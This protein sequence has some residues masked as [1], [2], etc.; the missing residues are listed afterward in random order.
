[1]KALSKRPRPGE[2]TIKSKTGYLTRG[3][4]HLWVKGSETW[5][6]KI[7]C[8]IDPGFVNNVTDTPEKATC[9]KCLKFSRSRA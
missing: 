5:N 9:S 4:V 6:R 3:A 2:A 7:Y 1:M 8:G